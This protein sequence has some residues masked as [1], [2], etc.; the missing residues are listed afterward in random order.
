MLDGQVQE[1]EILVKEELVTG[2]SRVSWEK[3][4]VNFHNS[5][6]SI[7]AHSVIQVNKSSAGEASIVVD[8]PKCEEYESDSDNEYV[9]NDLVEPEK[10]SYA[11]FK[12]VKTPKQIVKEQDTCSENPKVGTRD[13]NGLMSKRLGLGYG[14]TK[15]TCFVCGRFSH[16][17]KDCDFHEKRMTNQ[18][19]MN[20]RKNKGTG[21]R[22]VRPVW[23]KAQRVTQ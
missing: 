11:S 20:K 6:S 10:P 3:V 9:I 16:L 4:D 1:L 7:A 19:E 17:I 22:E 5:R 23:N 15:K 21:Q 18:V 2:L 13:W 8:A 12:H 14:F